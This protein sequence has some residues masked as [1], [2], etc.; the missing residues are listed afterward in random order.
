ML[1]QGKIINTDDLWVGKCISPSYIL[2]M[3]NDLTRNTSNNPLLYN[4]TNNITTTN[5]TPEFVTYKLNT[6]P[7]VVI[8]SVQLSHTN[9]DNQNTLL[10]TPESKQLKN[11]FAKNVNDIVLRFQNN[12]PISYV[13]Y[14]K[15]VFES[16]D[17]D[18]KSANPQITINYT[19]GNNDINKRR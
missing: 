7:K 15:T 19:C 8:I 13:N 11:N 18:E 4:C 10:S 3:E 14:I 2:N 9:N 12:F 16:L 17:D 5:N 6:S 1:N